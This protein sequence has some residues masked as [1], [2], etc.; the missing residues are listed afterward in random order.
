MAGVIATIPKFQ[1]SANGVPMVGGTLDTYIAGST[2]P[3]TTWQDS[4]LTIAN[5]NPI[6]LDARGECVLW[7]DSTKSYKFVL[8]NASGVIQWTQDNIIGAGSLADK[9]RTDLAASSGSSLVGGASQVVNSIAA[10]RSLLKTSASKSAF[11]TGY[12]AAGDGGGGSYWYDAS[13]TTT[14]DN[15][16]TVIV[17]TDGGR[18]KLASLYTISTLQF[19]AKGDGLADDTAAIQ[20]A[21][22]SLPVG[23][24]VHGAGKKF[25]VKSLKLKSHMTFMNMNLVTKAGAE[26]LVSPITIDGRT[27]PKNNIRVLNVVVDG[28]RA[29]QTDITASAE[30]GGRHGFRLIGK[31]S[32]ILIGECQ[33]HNCGTDGI[34]IFS[35]TSV[36]PTDSTFVFSNITLRN[37]IG[38][39]NRRHGMSAD[40][41]ANSVL[42]GCEFNSNGLD[43]NTT[44]AGTHGNRGAR[45]SMSLANP[46]Y[47]NGID[48]EGYGLGS[49][50]NTLRLQSVTARGNA[51]AGVLFYDPSSL[52]APGF[53]RRQKIWISDSY[54]DAG[55]DVS[56]SGAALEFTSTVAAEGTGILYDGVYVANTR[57]DGALWTRCVN[58]LR[59]EGD[60]VYSGGADVYFAKLI[61]S[62]NIHLGAGTVGGASRSVN[63]ISSTYTVGPDTLPFPAAPTLS[64]AGGSAGTLSGPVVSQVARLGGRTFRFFIT[65]TWTASATGVPVFAITPA[66][67]ST[68]AT[69]P[70][71]VLLREADAI[72]VPA[73]YLMSLG[74]F[75]FSDQN[76]GAITMQITVD[77]TV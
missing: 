12:Y 22:D 49:S 1:F 39:G 6:S 45:V 61:Y 27:E 17:A 19:G 69:P 4:A 2:T 74:N 76:T 41:I 38:N 21:I 51:R 7:L 37:F 33:A 29:N 75:R 48:F 26:N 43:L 3:A 62:T 16:G 56:R 8:K 25:T 67:G 63:A 23:G 50:I 28:N 59:F 10:L 18:W 77:V 42:I 14:A 20:A 9:L 44:D 15:S 72:A 60:I 52:T 71:L 53:A 36:G 34:E 68:I 40:S 11:V 58:N 46:L 24:V 66:E 5:T 57:L 65:A 31:M 64:K 55:V 13:D 70:E 30:D 47:G 73:G 32:E 35:D 54:F